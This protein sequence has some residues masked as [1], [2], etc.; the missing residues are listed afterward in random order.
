[1]IA[2]IWARIPKKQSQL[3][4]FFAVGG[5]NT[6]FGYGV[7]SLFVFVG[8]PPTVALV[9]AT[10]IAILFNFVTISR[11]VFESR[12]NRLLLR[13]SAVYLL[14]YVINAVLLK[15]VIGAGLNPYL[16]QALLLPIM[17]LGVFFGQKALVFG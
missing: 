4:R 12:D 16:A 3:F 2:A 1:M 7:Y 8:L 11:L 17:A 5:V 10:V 6:A 14:A 15:L 9:P 13:F